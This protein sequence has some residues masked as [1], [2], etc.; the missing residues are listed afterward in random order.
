ME[1]EKF[2]YSYFAPTKEEKRQV[3]MIKLFY[4]ESDTPKKIQKLKSLDK[5]VKETPTIVALILGIIGTLIFGTGFALVLEFNKM[6]L[7]IIIAVI[8]IILI[9]LAY[10][11]YKSVA[12]ALKKKHKDKII[13]LA[14]EILEEEK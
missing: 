3:E 14:N 8:G 2:E 10:P 6:V 4:E 9:A 7:G 1:K 5:M 11:V 13:K 12:N